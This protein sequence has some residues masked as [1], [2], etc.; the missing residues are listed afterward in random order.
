MSQRATKHIPAPHECRRVIL[1][2]RVR[3]KERLVNNEICTV[4]SLSVAPEMPSPSIRGIDV[5][6]QPTMTV[7]QRMGTSSLR[8]ENGR[9]NAVL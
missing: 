7:R 3:R 5:K 1:E 4:L 9:T 6:N 8:D 2:A